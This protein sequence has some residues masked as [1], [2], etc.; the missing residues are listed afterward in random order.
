MSW[1]SRKFKS[2]TRAIDPTN[3][4]PVKQALHYTDDKVGGAKGWSVVTRG[5]A[6]VASTISVAFPPAAIIT[7]PL[8]IAAGAGTAALGETA[9]KQA[10]SKRQRE[11]ATAVAAY[12]TAQANLSPGEKL[13]STVRANGPVLAIAFVGILA[14]L[15]VLDD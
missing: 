1:L 2:V 10:A 12:N 13:T 7:G 8:A 15:F 5:V 3:I 4:K 14:V 11:A 9:A 6:T